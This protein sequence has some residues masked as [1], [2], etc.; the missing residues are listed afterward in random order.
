M[1]LDLQNAKQREISKNV[2]ETWLLNKI[3]LDK[4]LNSMHIIVLSCLEQVKN[5]DILEQ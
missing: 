4:L 5:V 1:Y 3:Y 2:L